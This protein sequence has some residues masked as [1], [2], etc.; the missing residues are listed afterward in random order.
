[1]KRP[2]PLAGI[3]ALRTW[4]NEPHNRRRVT[5]GLIALG[6][7][8]LRGTI[9]ELHGRQDQLEEEQ[10]SYARLEDVARLRVELGR[11]RQR[12][13]ALE[14]D[15]E[16]PVLTAPAESSVPPDVDEAPLVHA[17]GLETP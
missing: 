14:G 4:L 3:R 13:H 11:Q 12:L 8:A 16:A 2:H 9:E 10:S 7:G 15:V 5:I 17:E 1:M 6:F